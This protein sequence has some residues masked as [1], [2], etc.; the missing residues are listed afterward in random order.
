MLTTFFTASLLFGITYITL[1][2]LIILFVGCLGILEGIF[3]PTQNT[4][5]TFVCP[6][7]KQGKMFGISLFVEGFS[8]T[9]APTLY[10]WVADQSSLIYAYRFATIPLSISLVLY[11]FLLFLDSKK[12][13]RLK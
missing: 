13:S 6:V 1:P 10:G 7:H 11:V 2:W 5:L 3:F 9:L 8:A 12:N 4:W